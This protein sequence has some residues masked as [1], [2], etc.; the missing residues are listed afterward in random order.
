MSLLTVDEIRLLTANPIP[1]D[2]PAGVNVRLE[3]AFESIE[4]E[5]AKLDSFTTDD[6]VRWGNVIATS[7]QILEEQSKD[8]W[9]IRPI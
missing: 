7:R 8:F 1:G 6:P 5:I 9:S 2:N 3:Q 4:Q